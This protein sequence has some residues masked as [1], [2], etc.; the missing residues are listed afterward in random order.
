MDQ[1]DFDYCDECGGYGTDYRWDE[2][3][4]KIV[5][6]CSYCSFNPERSDD[7]ETD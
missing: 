4:E 2:R 5:C 1:E 3:N 6:N 7:D